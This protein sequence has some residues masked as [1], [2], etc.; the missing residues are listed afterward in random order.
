MEGVLQVSSENR[1]TINYFPFR[2]AYDLTKDEIRLAISAEG[3]E[4]TTQ[5]IIITFPERRRKCSS[6][7]TFKVMVIHISLKMKPT[8]DGA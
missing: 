1:L 6:K 4:G 2:G 5:C 7:G 3:K 8:N